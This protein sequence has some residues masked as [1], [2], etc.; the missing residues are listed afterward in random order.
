MTY[1][2]TPNRAGTQLRVRSR[3][4]AFASK[5]LLRNTGDLSVP[6]LLPLS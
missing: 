5:Y 3:G 1:C 2:L 6:E 4:P